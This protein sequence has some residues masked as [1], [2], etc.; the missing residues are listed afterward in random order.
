[1]R[2]FVRGH[3]AYK[4]DSVVSSEIA[5]DLMIACKEIGEGQR[6]VPELLGDFRIKPIKPDGSWDV[7]LDSKT[8]R[9]DDI[10]NLLRRY[11]NRKSHFSAT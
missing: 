4:K 1:M 2:K 6:H 9:N 5:Y 10:L 3:P 8:V 7:K 11:T